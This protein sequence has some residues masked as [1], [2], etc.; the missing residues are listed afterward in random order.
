MNAD[1]GYQ[2]GGPVAAMHQAIET[3][4]IAGNRSL[5]DW[6]LYADARVPAE[7]T[8]H[9]LSRAIGVAALGAGL[10]ATFAGLNHLF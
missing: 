1:V 10:L 4:V 6:T 2:A 8:M 7:E 9:Q 5:P 3:H